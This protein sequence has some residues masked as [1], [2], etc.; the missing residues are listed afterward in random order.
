MRFDVKEIWEKGQ[1]TRFFLSLRE[2]IC[3]PF[4]RKIL[5][6]QLPEEDSAWGTHPQKQVRLDKMH[7]FGLLISIREFDFPL[8]KLF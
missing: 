2:K 5:T 4:A 1:S 3:L 6:R 8:T 7:D